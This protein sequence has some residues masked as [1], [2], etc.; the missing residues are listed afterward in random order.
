MWGFCADGR[1]RSAILQSYFGDDAPVT[2]IRLNYHRNPVNRS[3]H[4]RQSPDGRITKNK[5]HPPACE[6]P[7]GVLRMFRKGEPIDGK[8]KVRSLESI[9]TD[10]QD[11]DIGVV[12]ICGSLLAKLGGRNVLVKVSV[13]GLS[14]RKKSL[15]RI[16]RAS[17]GSNALKNNEIALQYDDRELLG[18]RSFESEYDIVIERVFQLISQPSFLWNHTSPLVRMN[19]AFAVVLTLMGTALGFF[20]GCLS[21]INGMID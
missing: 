21:S 12:R 1:V 2:G 8:F 3:T 4:G 5:R 19:A 17:T 14:G 9:G 20:I 18:I 15:I 11:Y 7:K 6:R 10:K 13:A 16:V